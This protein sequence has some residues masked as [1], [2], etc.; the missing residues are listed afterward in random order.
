[1]NVN[2]S[3]LINKGEVIAVALSGGGDSM[4]LLNILL[5]NSNKYGYTVIALNVEHGIRGEESIKDS[6]FVKD[7]C[8]KKG[9][10]LL[11][12]EVDSIKTAK[13]QKLSIEQ[14]ARQ[15][16]YTCFYKAISD[17][18]C[19]KVATAHHQSDN[20]ESVLLNIFRGTGLKGII[21]IEQNY[22]DKIIRPLLSV[23]KA[24]IEN[25]LSA[26]NIPFVTD[27][28]NLSD[29]YTRNYLRINIMPKLKEIFPEVENSILRLAEIASEDEDYIDSVATN[30]VH[31]QGDRA[32][33]ILPQHKAVLSRA[34]IKAIKALGVEKD[35]TKTHLNDVYALSF[36]Q[37]GSMINLP[38]SI[39]AIREYD[40]I[41]FFKNQTQTNQAIPFYIGKTE[42]ANKTINC[43]Q[44][45]VKG[46]N[47]RDG[48]YA[49]SAKIPNDALIRFRQDG[50]TFTKFGGGT[51]NL[52]DYLT[53]KKI[54]LKDR[55]TLPLLASG[56]DILV[57]FGVAVSDKVKA[58][59]STTTVIKFDIQ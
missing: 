36:K 27:S 4:A 18:L 41:V 2:F 19:D 59:N 56:N 13:E 55:D 24:E 52:G 14:S 43:E 5:E 32:E 45:S 57:I 7:Y 20:A 58:D 54:P 29:E 21:G 10:K 25:Y 38:K 3:G 15:L 47:L 39:V 49:D 46:I 9:V 23:G 17:G 40:K 28:T 48:L 22:K 42:Y 12:F 30:T 31:I 34:T 26:N 44:L 37:T 33:I 6:A 51:K 1:M 8:E 11:S 16:R 53:D 35:W 50:D